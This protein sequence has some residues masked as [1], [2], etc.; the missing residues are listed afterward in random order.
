MPDTPKIII[1]LLLVY[2]ISLLILRNK[3]VWHKISGKGYSNLCPICQDHPLE[4]IKKQSK[5]YILNYLTFQIFNFKR[6]KCI[7]CLNSFMRWEKRF[8]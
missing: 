6:Y 3:K 7:K 2:F 1:L 4:R 5:D 8:R